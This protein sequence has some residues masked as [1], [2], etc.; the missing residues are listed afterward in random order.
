M[1]KNSEIHLKL[2][3]E[4][5]EK[6]KKQ[7]LD[8]SVSISELCRRKIKDAPQLSKIEFLLTDIS[9]KIN[10]QLNLNRRYKMTKKPIEDEEEQPE[11][12]DEKEE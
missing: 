12:L 7:A 4:L 3:T 2:E 1:R 10:A 6:I 5:F 11:D 9:G 8:D